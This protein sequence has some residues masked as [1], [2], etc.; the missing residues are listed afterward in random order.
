MN[1]KIC[2]VCG[3]E[4]PLTEEFFYTAWNRTKTVRKFK[5][6]C[7]TCEKKRVSK[8]YDKNYIPVDYSL[9]E[10]VKSCKTCGNVY[11]RTIEYFPKSESKNSFKNICHNCTPPPPPKQKSGRKPI[12][13]GETK[14]CTKCQ[15]TYPSTTEHFQRDKR[16]IGGL[17]AICKSCRHQQ[18]IEYALA[19]PDKIKDM[20]KKSHIRCR[21]KNNARVRTWYY[22]NP[23]KAKAGYKRNY[24]KNRKK[25]YAYAN[26]R[27]HRRRANGGSHTPAE[28]D[29]LY[30][31]QGGVCFYCGADLS[32][33]YHKDH[34]IPIF[35]GGD[36][37]I[38]NI[39]LACQPCNNSKGHKLPWIFDNRCL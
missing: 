27:I 19:N 13:L 31:W 4:F 39:V 26:A 24:E 18:K 2:T 38:H 36:N 7:K 1:T 37:T 10:D 20:K 32:N 15:T 21:D 33:G 30:E 25:Y 16:G 11:P 29:E 22:A 5:S 8:W 34:Y 6:L 3:Q 23:E 9:K 14:T 17:M 12:P 28:I 35:L